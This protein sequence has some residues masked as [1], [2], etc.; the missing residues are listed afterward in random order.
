[1]NWKYN[2]REMRRFRAA[3]NVMVAGGAALLV[4]VLGAVLTGA[5]WAG[6]LSLAA[7]ALLLGG[8]AACDANN[9]FAHRRAKVEHLNRGLAALVEKDSEP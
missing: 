1:M 2:R 6:W 5:P 9:R 3:V 4:G 7:V 8:T